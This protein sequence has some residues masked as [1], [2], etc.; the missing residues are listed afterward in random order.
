M[1]GSGYLEHPRK[2]PGQAYRPV[3]MAGGKAAQNERAKENTG[4]AKH[5][6][7]IPETDK[8]ENRTP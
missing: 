1:A 8:T 4:K 3:G 2:A 6:Q 5:R 7:A